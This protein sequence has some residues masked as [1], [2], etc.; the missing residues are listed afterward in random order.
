[1][2][3]VC[4]SDLN[5][6]SV[7][8]L[9]RMLPGFTRVREKGFLKGLVWL[10]FVNFCNKINTS[11]FFLWNIYLAGPLLMSVSFELTA[12][13]FASI[14]VAPALVSL[15]ERSEEH[16]SELQSRFDLVCRL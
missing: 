7:A 4:S 15:L 6:V 3:D 2:S 12:N 16:T 1:S 11:L 14:S 5:A 13:I 9:S 8:S 10:S